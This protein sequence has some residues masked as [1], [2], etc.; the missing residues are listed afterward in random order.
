VVNVKKLIQKLP[1][2][3]GKWANQTKQEVVN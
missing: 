2:V 3:T 1:G